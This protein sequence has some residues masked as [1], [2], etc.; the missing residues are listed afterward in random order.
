M[1]TVNMHDA[2]TRLSELVKAVEEKGEVV[3][4]CRDGKEVAEIRR[5]SKRA[6]S[7]NIDPD[8]KFRVEFA[9][10]YRPDEPLSE[11]EWPDDLR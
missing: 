4:L 2:K 3:I 5:R 1:I 10:G 8:P 9:R 11:D 6:Q 7:R